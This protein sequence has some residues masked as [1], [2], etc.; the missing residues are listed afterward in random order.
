[1]K[2]AF[3]NL[4]R[5]MHDE[6]SNKL[7]DIVAKWY[8]YYGNIWQNTGKKNRDINANKGYRKKGPARGGGPRRG[9]P[10]P[11]CSPVPGPKILIDPHRAFRQAKCVWGGYKSV[12][13]HYV[14]LLDGCL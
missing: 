14:R 12:K 7:S 6:F 3:E 1:M 11:I 4:V 10:G 5:E 13:V 9:H 8:P 2:N